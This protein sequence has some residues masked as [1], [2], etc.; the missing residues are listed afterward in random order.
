VRFSP[1]AAL[2]IIARR[3]RGVG[4]ELHLLRRP[5]ISRC[6]LALGVTCGVAWREQLEV[7]SITAFL[8]DEVNRVRSIDRSI[9]RSFV[10]SIGRSRRQGVGCWWRGARGG[11]LRSAQFGRVR[12]ARLAPGAWVVARTHAAACDLRDAGASSHARLV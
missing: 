9:V 7:G 5:L 4:E 11:R 8:L 1:R 3:L 12:R 10:R 6:F 2:G